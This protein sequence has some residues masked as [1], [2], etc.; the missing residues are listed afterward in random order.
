MTSAPRPDSIEGLFARFGPSYRWL[1]TATVMMG[2]I[3]TILT[4]TIVNVALP[5]IMGAF[6]MGQDKA[7]LL[8]TG[9]LAAMTGTMLLN[10]WMVETLGQ[11][12]TFMLAL[13]VFIAASAMGGLAPAEGV[14]I[15]ARVL[16]G[17]AA[18][19][20]QPLAMQTIFL[21]FPPEKR[22]SAMGIYGIGVVLAPAL[23]PTLGGIMVDSF[24][25]RYVFFM[26]VPFCFI[27]LFMAAILMP[28]R[29]TSGPPRKF[30]WIG[31]G[32]MT[33]FLVTLLNGLSNG[34]RDGWISDP[35][36][37]DFAIALVAGIGFI[38]W[39]LR[40]SAPMLNLKLFTNRVYAGASVVAFI[41]GAGIF[42]STFLIPLFVQTIQG[43]TPTRSG[44]L[45]MPA[46]LILALVFPIAGRLTDRTPA[47]ATVMFG[48]VIFALSSFLMSNVDTNTSFWLF[49]WWIML[50]RIGLG[51]IMPSLNAGA[52]KALPM[53]LLSQGSGAINFVRQ[54]GGAF[55]VNLLSIA[56]ERRSQLY[57]DSFT[58]AQHAGNS[59]TTA[60]LHE[61][62][63]LLAQAGVPEAIR[64]AGAMNYLGR[65]IYSQGNM[66]GYRDSFFIV[67]AIFL[68]A[69]VPALMMRR[70]STPPALQASEA[71]RHP[72][73]SQ[74]AIQQ[75]R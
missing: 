19:I 70:R 74:N 66:L 44:L 65:V 32:L 6:G 51:F 55:G 39:E 1:V 25:W 3:A 36:L 58:A 40:T 52:L 61:V 73:S 22:G 75:S 23:G 2:T 4:A 38:V 59:A 41:F 9:F 16:Q 49:A 8:S 34:Q 62:T 42:G 12:A 47:Y 67:G 50:G 29:A 11:R 15:L 31:F 21:V 14:L 5:D 69:L 63:G 7:Q 56:L 37:R 43:Y 33:V 46:G 53:T 20:L 17:G 71:M 48:L 57:V 10:A 54:L 68:A 30:D 60:M 24:S 27:G 18:G 35:I 28:G 13:T 72:P 64:Q 26:A 45:L